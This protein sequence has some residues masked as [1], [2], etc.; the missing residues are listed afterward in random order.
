MFSVV[1]KIARDEKTKMEDF[2]CEV[3]MSQE[4][5]EDKEMMVCCG[6]I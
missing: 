2:Q 3:E 5:S 1:V 6:E 4:G